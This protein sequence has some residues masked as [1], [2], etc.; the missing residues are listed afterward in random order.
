MY[1]D[2][3]DVIEGNLSLERLRADLKKNFKEDSDRFSMIDNRERL[4]NE[5]RRVEGIQEEI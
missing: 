5:G 1:K 2:H 3:N 4:Y